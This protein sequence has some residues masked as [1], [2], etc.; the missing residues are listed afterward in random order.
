MAPKDVGFSSAGDGAAPTLGRPKAGRLILQNEPKSMP[1]IRIAARTRGRASSRPCSEG[2]QRSFRVPQRFHRT[3][4]P[5]RRHVA[6]VLRAGPSPRCLAGRFAPKGRCRRPDP[7]RQGTSKVAIISDDRL[8]ERAGGT[9]AMTSLE[10][11]AIK[12]ECPHCG[13]VGTATVSDDGPDGE[14]CI[15][16]LSPGFVVVKRSMPVARHDVRC[17][18]CNSSALK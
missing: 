17:S 9:L 1:P 15:D 14:V 8:F 13:R 5:R 3:D 6:G 16:E 12:L 2:Q 7:V 4:A 11:W 18:T 10:A